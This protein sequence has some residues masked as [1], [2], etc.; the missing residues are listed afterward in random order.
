MRKLI[1]FVLVII[2]AIW[3][4]NVGLKNVNFEEE[5]MK[6]SEE[7]ETPSEIYRD[8]LNLSISEVDTLQP[9]RTKNS[10]VMSLLYLIYEPLISYNGS[11]ELEFVLADSF[12]KIDAK[13]WII[14]LRED[15]SWHG[16]EKFTANDVLFTYN[17][18]KSNDLVY[19]ANVSNV[20]SVEKLDNN[21]VKFLLQEDDDYF[22]HKLMFPIIPEYY[23]KSDAFLDENK[24]NAPVGTGA[25]QYVKTDENG[26]MELEFNQNW[27]KEKNAKL[28][29]I[30]VYRYTTYGEA[31]KAFKSAEVD[32]I[33]TNM[34][35]WKER[36]GTIG[37]N[38]YSF[39]NTKYEVIIPNCN[40]VALSENSVRRAILQAINRE[41]IINRICKE[42]ATICDIPIH[43]NSKNSIMNAEYDIEKAKQ[44]LINAG[45]TQ[46]ENTWT[47]KINEK[48]Y[49]LHFKL[50]VN[51]DSEEKL[52]IAEQ[53]KEDLNEI[54]IQVT[55]T[56]ASL[57]NIEKALQQD[58]FDLALVT[59]EI[60]EE[61]SI[62][63]NVVSDGIYNYANYSSEA[64]D[65][66]INA[67]KVDAT[68][69]DEKILELASLYKNDA[70]YIGLYFKNS[71]ILTNKSV[72]GNFE[73]TW[74]NVYRNITS[75]CK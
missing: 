28:Q 58:T 30:Y 60:K 17:L 43:T 39:E 23:F 7:I 35:G 52:A 13:T 64:M 6:E 53:I 24:A 41:N 9:L 70:S 72:K 62:M 44:I 54:G 25:Y 37:L 22:I 2:V 68:S 18:L 55:I 46:Q 20:E 21:A 66:L 69:Y 45:W 27:W 42:D 61:T 34:M 8:E 1:V 65:A 73:P 75:F 56:K 38:S 16:G 59:L 12:A 5:E 47:K 10:Q 57:E 63:E 11:E 14:K 33:A 48:E 36:F 31:L 40:H 50:L 19:S 67:M 29:R 74:S 71:T 32:M 15:V 3:G 26:T 51:K 4:L 49:H